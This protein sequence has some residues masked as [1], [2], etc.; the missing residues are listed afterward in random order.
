MARKL[1]QFI[2][3]LVVATL[4]N[5]VKVSGLT[6][7]W[8]P[9]ALPFVRD[10]IVGTMEKDFRVFER[11]LRPGATVLDLG[12]HIGL[13]SLYAAKIVGPKG[14][15]YAFEPDPRIYPL[16]V[17]NIDVNGFSGVIH[18]EQKAVLHVN[19][20]VSFYLSGPQ[21]PGYSSIYPTGIKDPQCIKVEAVTLDSFLASLGWP[22][23]DI[24]KMDIEGSELLAFQGMK[25]VVR[26]NPQL[27]MIVEFGVSRF[28]GVEQAFLFF[29]ALRSLGFSRF[30]TILEPNK[31]ITTREDIIWLFNQPIQNILCER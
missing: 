27:K 31:L 26:R 3:P 12:A 23:I 10:F 29:D 5:P 14:R 20:P 13:Y 7:Y 15:I 1:N 11:L 21:E 6:I 4:P 2:E 17:K 30:S 25:E 19:G 18:A 9:L 8:S 16:L 22:A 24:I 28:G